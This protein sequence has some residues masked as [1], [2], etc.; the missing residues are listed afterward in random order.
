[1]LVRGEFREPT[2]P[3]GSANALADVS[4]GVD[5]QAAQ[6]GAASGDFGLTPDDVALDSLKRGNFDTK[7]TSGTTSFGGGRTGILRTMAKPQAISNASRTHRSMAASA[8]G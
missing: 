2:L 1:M 3:D 5:P 4:R 8:A 6:H 7:T